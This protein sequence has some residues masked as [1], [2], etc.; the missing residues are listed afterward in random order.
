MM[1]CTGNLLFCR[2]H[3]EAKTNWWLF[4]VDI[5]KFIFVYGNCCI[6]MGIVLQ[7][8]SKGPINDTPVSERRWF[9]LLMHLYISIT[10]PRLMK[11]PLHRKPSKCFLETHFSAGNPELQSFLQHVIAYLLFCM[12]FRWPDYIFNTL[13]PRQNGHHFQ[14]T[15]SNAFSSM[16]LYEFRLKFHWSL[17]LGSN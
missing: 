16:K 3:I 4:T 2:W 6:P 14:T 11:P 17:F 7:F 15:F 9:C 5:L 1:D 12:T 8:A 10:K 13:R